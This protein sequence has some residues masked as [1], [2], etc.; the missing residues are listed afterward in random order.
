M[1]GIADAD[2]GAVERP[3]GPL[4][5]PPPYLAGRFAGAELW[6]VRPGEKRMLEPGTLIHADAD[7]T[8]PLHAIGVV[9]RNINGTAI[10]LVAGAMG[11]MASAREPGRVIGV[12]LVAPYREG[13]D[14][15]AALGSGAGTP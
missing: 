8:D 12:Q 6:V 9:V 3:A 11:Q 13:M 4:P 5:L 1:V 15:A 14:L 2:H 7:T 10:A